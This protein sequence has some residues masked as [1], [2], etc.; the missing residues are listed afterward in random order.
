MPN[1]KAPPK[2]ASLNYEESLYTQGHTLICGIDEVGRGPLAGSVV[3]CAVI[4]PKGLVI[5]GV[6]D[7][8]ALS[9]KRR[10][11]LAAAI[12]EAAVDY[13]LGWADAD[14]IDE[15][16]ILQAT[17][18]A[19]SRALEN[20]KTPPDAVLIDGLQGKWVPDI[21]STFI[22]GGDRASHSIAA[23]SIV[24]KVARDAEMMRL[25]EAYPQ[26]GFDTHKGYGTAKH[27][28]ALRTHGPCP[29]HRRSFI[30]KVL[31]HDQ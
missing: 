24:A 8:K 3:A 1:K 10:E 22:K 19:M 18:A 30:K 15:I 13:A 14:L 11:E 31:N 5:P 25:H 17:Y 4:L 2:T 23:A 26:Y 27:V 9:A 12:K 28:E 29:S 7:S 20:L 6:Y 16:N 21:P